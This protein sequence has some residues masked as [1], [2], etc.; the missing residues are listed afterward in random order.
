MKNHITKIVLVV[1][2]LIGLLVIV[3]IYDTKIEE[4]SPEAVVV[5]GYEGKWLGP[6][7][8]AVH[9]G[10]HIKRKSDPRSW[11]ELGCANLRYTK[12]HVVF[13]KNGGRSRLNSHP[14][15]EDYYLLGDE[16]KIKE[17]VDEYQ[18]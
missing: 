1:G 14:M 7:D 8:G 18:K 10:F 15:I 6:E 12:D 9:Y 3:L 17:I 13:V 4:F 2:T 11:E 16:K 5:P